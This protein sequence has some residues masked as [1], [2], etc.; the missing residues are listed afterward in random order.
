MTYVNNIYFMK[1]GITKNVI[2]N[3]TF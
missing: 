1:S 2:K 3:H